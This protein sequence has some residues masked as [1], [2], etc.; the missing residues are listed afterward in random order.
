[1][2]KSKINF[3]INKNRLN[4]NIEEKNFSGLTIQDKI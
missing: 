2:N 4:N 3:I 1:M